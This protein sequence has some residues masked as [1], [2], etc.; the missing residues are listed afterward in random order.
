MPSDLGKRDILRLEGFLGKFTAARR[1]GKTS[2]V[3]DLVCAKLSRFFRPAQ[4]NVENKDDNKNGKS[5][6]TTPAETVTTAKT[7]RTKMAITRTWTW[8]GRRTHSIRSYVP[9]WLRSDKRV[10]SRS[11]IV[12]GRGKGRCQELRYEWVNRSECGARARKP[13]NQRRN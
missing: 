10:V 12:N 13:T 4:K 3:P 6:K 1:F 2:L 9:S 5:E 7:R 8:G 11:T